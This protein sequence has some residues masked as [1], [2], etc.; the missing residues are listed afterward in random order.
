MRPTPQALATGPIDY[1]QWNALNIVW[2][3][4]GEV[5]AT[6]T[7]FR[8]TI[9]LHDV[10]YGNVK[11]TRSFTVPTASSP[12]FR[13]ATHAISDEVVR[14]VFGQP[15]MA[16][17][18]VAFVRQNG[19]GKYDLLLVDSDGEN[20]RR[21]GGSD[22]PIYSPSWSPDGSKL[23]YTVKL[24][25][26]WEMV[27]RDMVTGRTRVLVE[28]AN[29]ILTPRYSPDGSRMAFA[30]W[31]GNGFEIR[32]MDLNG[33]GSIRTLTNSAGDNLSP[34]YSPDGQSI[35]FHSTRTGRQHIYVMPAAGGN[36]TV[37]TPFGEGVEYAAPEW[38]P[39]GTEVTFHGRSRGG[40]YQIMLANASRPGGRLEQLT[41]EGE[42]EDPSWAPDGR[43]IVYSSG[44]RRGSPGLYVIDTRTG[45]IR[46]LA[47]G[48]RLRIAD[49]SPSLAAPFLEGTR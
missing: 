41:R 46:S 45:N 13:M 16:A 2:V 6:P 24:E 9:A 22:H 27:E 19:N 20:L 8:V 25:E 14:W 49:W 17:S 29:V 21:I 18:R 28:D 4:A 12:D 39:T 43:H 33:N 15:G 10:V 36:A 32:E 30:T 44:V 48:G 35:V 31:A 23:A 40:V 37:L 11:E 1:P 47:T 34:A 3:V 7:G 5:L 26:G 38:S 42:N